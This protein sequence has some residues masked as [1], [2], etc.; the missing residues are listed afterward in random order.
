ME[1]GWSWKRSA[2]DCDRTEPPGMARPRD[3]ERVTPSRRELH[4]TMF[5]MAGLDEGNRY[6]LYRMP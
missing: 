2:A 5:G 4:A 6:P 3:Y 1:V